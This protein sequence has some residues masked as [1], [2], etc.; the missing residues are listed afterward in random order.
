MKMKSLVPLAFAG[1]MA[2]ALLG[3]KPYAIAEPA[4]VAPPVEAGVSTDDDVAAPAAATV[5]VDYRKKSEQSLFPAMK[6]ALVE[7]IRA[8]QW[9]AEVTPAEYTMLE[10]LR[11]TGKAAERNGTEGLFMD[12]LRLATEQ[13]WY[14]DG[15]DDNE[16]KA[17]TA[18][19]RAYQSSLADRYVTKVGPLM[20]SSLRGNYFYVL[21]LPE[22]G[23]VTIVLSTDPEYANLGR[24][25]LDLAVENLPKVEQIVGKFP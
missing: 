18:M 19:F 24:K 16:A 2:L 20:A 25:A 23:E 10:T 22:S 8:Q 11:D 6:P 12:T 17:M 5:S 3:C 4:L 14:T 7:F 15:F 1:V 21:Q 9:F 13:W